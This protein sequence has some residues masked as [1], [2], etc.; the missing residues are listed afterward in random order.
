MKRIALITGAT[1]GFGEAA[2]RRFIQEGWY[3]IGTGRRAERLDE[4]HKVLGERF[5]PLC[6][7]VRDAQCVNAGIASLPSPD[8]KSVV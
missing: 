1:S 8:R 5:F 7:D 3:V 6:F 2:T 4:M